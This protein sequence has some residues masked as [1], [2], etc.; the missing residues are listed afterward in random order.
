MIQRLAPTM[1]VNPQG[2]GTERKPEALE[3]H[4]FTSFFA[5]F[6]DSLGSKAAAHAA[7]SKALKTPVKAAESERPKE[8]KEESSPLAHG[9]AQQPRETVREHSAAQPQERH[10]AGSDR[11]IRPEASSPVTLAPKDRAEPVVE[12]SPSKAEHAGSAQVSRPQGAASSG[13]HGPAGQPT[14]AAVTASA[15][16]VAGAARTTPVAG[17]GAAGA[18]RADGMGRFVGVGSPAGVPRGAANAPTARPLQVTT[19]DVVAQFSR[20]LASALRTNGGRI[21]LRLHPEAL[22]VV[23]VQVQVN[24]GVVEA[25]LEADSAQ[26]RRLLSDHLPQLGAMLEARGLTV[27]RL[28]VMADL[29]GDRPEQ[30]NPESSGGNAGRDSASSGRDEAEPGVP[31]EDAAA[32]AWAEPEVMI[33]ERG[34]IRLNAVA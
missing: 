12:A 2:G 32:D 30:A 23:R 34:V 13:T 11:Q 25:S 28:E 20:G 9:E 27:G 31:R 4:L 22:G 7:A 18:I 16:K 3:A 33:D 21:S 5:I 17:A 10:G 24:Q 26:A 15:I 6:K 29:G 14:P 19:E 1:Q 8:R